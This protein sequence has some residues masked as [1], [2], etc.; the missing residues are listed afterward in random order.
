MAAEQRCATGGSSSDLGLQTGIVRSGS[1]VEACRRRAGGLRGLK[2][3]P[4]RMAA[5]T[6]RRDGEGVVSKCLRRPF[7]LSRMVW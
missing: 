4:R 3:T 2:G 7:R 5:D 6:D 1:E